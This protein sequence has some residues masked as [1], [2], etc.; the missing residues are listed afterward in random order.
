MRSLNW[1]KDRASFIVVISLAE[2]RLAPVQVAADFVEV[3]DAAAA[4]LRGRHGLG[5]DPATHHVFRDV[6]QP[7]HLSEYRLGAKRSGTE[8]RDLFHRACDGEPHYSRLFH[9]FD[10]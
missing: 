3:D 2:D 4:N 9:G 1:E 5:F 7:Q 10:L 8:V 6:L